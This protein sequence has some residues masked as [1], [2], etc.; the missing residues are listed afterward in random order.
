MRA[1]LA[2]ERRSVRVKKKQARKLGSGN[3]RVDLA[4][5]ND[6][7][8]ALDELRRMGI[9]PKGYNLLAP[10]DVARRGHLSEPDDADELTVN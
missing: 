9:T 2:T 6:A 3:P 1:T 4:Q 5:V 8:E 7:L 10:T